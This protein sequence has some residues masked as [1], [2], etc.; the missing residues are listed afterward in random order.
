MILDEP[1]AAIDPIEERKIYN[2]FVTLI[3]GN[4]AFIVTHRLGSVKLADRI[5]V[6]DKGKIVGDGSHDQLM[7]NCS[8][9]WR[10]FNEQKKWYV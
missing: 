7:E 1:T 2:D 5:I 3:Q 10:L 8:H 6:L 4:T 9:Y